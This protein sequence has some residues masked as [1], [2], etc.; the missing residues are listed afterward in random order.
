MSS[1]SS[2]KVQYL[3]YYNDQYLYFTRSYFTATTIDK[4]WTTHKTYIGIA[5][6]PDFLQEKT[7]EIV[8]DMKDYLPS[9]DEDWTLISQS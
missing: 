1:R 3:V 4:S 6:I 8:T 5:S 7:M 2:A 9:Q